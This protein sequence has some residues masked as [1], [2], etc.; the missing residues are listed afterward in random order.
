MRVNFLDAS[1][2]TATAAPIP[3]TTTRQFERVVAPEPPQVRQQKQEAQPTEQFSPPVNFGVKIPKPRDLDWLG[4]VRFSGKE[5]LGAAQQISS[6]NRPEEFWILALN[7]KLDGTALM[8]FERMP[9]L[10][11]AESPTLEDV[12]NRLL[13]PYMATISAAKGLQLMTAEKQKNHTWTDHYQYLTYV[14]ER[15]GCGDLHILQ[16]L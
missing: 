16:S 12:M 4:F 13:V 15:S 2:P 5:R 7:G 1:V 6:G 9:L 8:Y 10:W 3:A 11:T 14:A